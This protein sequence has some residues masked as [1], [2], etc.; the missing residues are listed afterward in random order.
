V[1]CVHAPCWQ[2]CV[3]TL[4]VGKE[5]CALGS[6]TLLAVLCDDTGRWEGEVCTGF[7]WLQWRASVNIAMDLPNLMQPFLTRGQWTPKE[8]VDRFQEVRELGWEEITTLFS[9][10]PD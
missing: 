7:I 10:N 3:M 9:P 6:C 1:H 8:S 5:N 4:G 2:Y